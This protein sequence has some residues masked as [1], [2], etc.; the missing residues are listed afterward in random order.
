[1]TENLLASA[2]FCADAEDH[3][4]KLSGHCHLAQRFD[5]ASAR[6]GAL[7][8]V[9]VRVLS[10]FGCA[11]LANRRAKL[12]DLLGE[13]ATARHKSSCQSAD[14]RAVD[15]ERDAVRHHISGL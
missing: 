5:A 13:R 6:L 11:G 15:V 10:A 8:A 4:I 14:R 3:A 9:L 1:M 2:R 12:A 7:L